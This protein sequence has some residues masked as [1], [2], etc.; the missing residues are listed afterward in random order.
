MI[1]KELLDANYYINKLS[2]F[3]RESYGIIPQINILIDWINSV[4]KT[5]DLIASILDIWNEDY[6]TMVEEICG[7]GES[8]KPFLPLDVIASIVGCSREN[9]IEVPTD[10]E[11]QEVYTEIDGGTFQFSLTG[12]YGRLIVSQ[13]PITEEYSETVQNYRG[14][15]YD[16]TY[17]SMADRYIESFM[18]ERESEFVYDKS[19]N[20][21]YFIGD[22]MGATSFVT[23]K[24][25][26]QTTPSSQTKGLIGRQL[27]HYDGTYYVSVDNGIK[28][29]L[30]FENQL[31]DLVE[32]ASTFTIYKKKEVEIPSKL[33]KEIVTL[34]NEE[35]LELIKVK[36]LQNNYDGSLEAIRDLYINKLRYNIY[37]SLIPNAVGN[38]EYQS[39]SCNIY[40][41]DNKIPKEG[42]SVGEPISENIKK[43]FKY[44]DFFIESLGIVYNKLLITDIDRLLILNRDYGEEYHD[45]PDKKALYDDNYV[46]NDN[47]IVLG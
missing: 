27:I 11:I 5:S 25:G 46:Q 23:I 41:D 3:M 20:I 24:E 47:S 13:D 45:D 8:E 6:L 16:W 29:Q 38:T 22:D 2:M 31:E 42:Q 33:K 43:I 21:G 28:Q 26:L 4:D 35:L 39:A 14:Y 7:T 18:I 10:P 1:K 19:K 12:T 34:N 40:L 17:V 32:N 36:I 30:T 9:I 37:Y 44:S 15:Y